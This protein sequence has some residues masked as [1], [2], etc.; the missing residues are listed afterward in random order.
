MRKLQP[1]DFTEESLNDLSI[2]SLG[3]FAE[4][5]NVPLSTARAYRKLK[6]ITPAHKAP[7]ERPH[8]MI[9]GIEHKW[10]SHKE[11]Y[12]PLDNFISDR[13][14]K[15]GLR[16]YCKACDSEKRK[17]YPS[18]E[19]HAEQM[20]EWVQ[21]EKGKAYTTRQAE[22][23]KLQREYRPRSEI[24]KAMWATLTNEERKQRTQAM[25]SLSPE[26]E[27]LRRQHLGESLQGH[28][29]SDETLQKMSE[30][31]KGKP[32]TE[33][34][35]KHISEAIL[36]RPPPSAETRQKLSI[37]TARNNKLRDSVSD[38][39]RKKMS[40]AHKGAKRA[41][42]TE[43]ARKNMSLARVGKSL[44]DAHRQK[45]SE[46]LAGREITEAH[47]ENLSKALTGK[48]TG[49]LA[50]GWKGGASEIPY[51]SGFTNY[52]KSKIK[53]RD[54]NQ[55]QICLTEVK[56]RAVRIHHINSIKAD[57]SESNLILLCSKCHGAIHATNE[58]TNPTILT[59]RS[60]LTYEHSTT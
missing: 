60:K 43:Q 29:F 41:P 7:I 32:L 33:E 19:K 50:S 44:N 10:C 17:Q 4:K 52:L 39:T 15:D 59:Y 46:A 3:Q 48:Y 16:A 20:R 24:A 25:R 21:T 57:V 6:N 26:K 42:Y 5:Y 12:M 27:A 35:R 53:E 55:C 37:A 40:I 9:D 13:T 14:T 31:K 47:R 1:F 28:G 36:Q 34:H 8:E 54:H 58:T 56:G 30:A 11:H 23:D 51:P 49:E 2:L 18:H 38:E 45:I 22:L